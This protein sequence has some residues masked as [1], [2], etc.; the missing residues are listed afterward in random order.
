MST[1]FCWGKRERERRVLRR[2]LRRGYYTV[3]GDS[4]RPEPVEPVRKRRRVEL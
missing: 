3:K 4:T 2:A 1:L